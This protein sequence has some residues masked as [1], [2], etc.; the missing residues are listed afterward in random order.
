MLALLHRQRLELRGRLAERDG[1][2]AGAVSKSTPAAWRSPILTRPTTKTTRADRVVAASSSVP[3]AHALSAAAAEAPAPPRA[4]TRNAAAAPRTPPPLLS[5]KQLTRRITGAA[6]WR[7]AA[8]AYDDAASETTNAIHLAAAV[9][10]AGR[11]AG[12]GRDKASAAATWVVRTL[13]R[14][15]PRLLPECQP[16]QLATLLWSLSAALGVTHDG[17]EGMAQALAAAL[18]SSSSSSSSAGRDVVSSAWALASL[19]ARRPG[20]PASASAAALLLPAAWAA[21]PPERLAP[22]PQQLGTLLRAAA[23]LSL[24]SPPGAASSALLLPPPSWLE[25][26]W[27]MSSAPGWWLR[28]RA[29][30]EAA[31]TPGDAAAALWGGAR[32]GLAAGAAPPAAWVAAALQALGGAGGDAAAS[33]AEAASALGALRMLLGRS[34]LLC[35]TAGPAAQAWL[36]ALSQEGG[37]SLSAAGPDGLVTLARELAAL[38]PL[39]VPAPE[40]AARL[41]RRC[42]RDCPD[43]ASAVLVAVHRLL[44][45]SLQQQLGEEEAS[46]LSAVAAAAL[47]AVAAAPSSPLAPSAA[48]CVHAAAALGCPPSSDSDAD[49]A[50]DA[51]LRQQGAA[52]EERA[53]D[54][55]LALRAAATWA[56]TAEAA[57]A[58]A[59]SSAWWARARS[60]V[61]SPL[62]RQVQQQSGRPAAAQAAVRLLAALAPP[63]AAPPPLQQQQQPELLELRR[64]LWRCSLLHRHEAT[65]VEAAEL[66]LLAGRA[67]GGRLRPPSQRWLQAALRGVVGAADSASP[68]PER[69]LQLLRVLARW[70]ALSSAERD[71]L[72][73]A[74]AAA[75]VPAQQ[76]PSASAERAVRALRAASRLPEPFPALDPGWVDA[77]VDAVVELDAGQGA[78]ATVADSSSRSLGR[79]QRRPAPPAAVAAL[80]L[81]RLLNPSSAGAPPAAILAPDRAR[82][83]LLAVAHALPCIERPALAVAVLHA[84]AAVAARAGAERAAAP[85]ADAWLE[86][87][88]SRGPAAFGAAMGGVP[89]FT[90]A[91]WALAKSGAVVMDGEMLREVMDAACWPPA[92]DET[93][94]AGAAGRGAEGPESAAPIPSPAS[95]WTPQR[96]ANTLCAFTRLGFNPG[97]ERLARLGAELRDAGAL[98]GRGGAAGSGVGGGGAM[99]A[100]DQEVIVAAWADLNGSAYRAS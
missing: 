6:D 73:A 77:V 30:D 84:S 97:A 16:R 72:V 65:P 55:G 98:G 88:S 44:G 5:P 33:A 96:L 31:C 32:L 59:P 45:G 48:A 50:L 47:A 18:S 92:D 67:A 43:A 53:R 9:W 13:R 24:S 80:A 19:E 12:G 51:A 82:R 11:A 66:L 23:T 57:A 62:L 89:G 79:R 90:K 56:A 60:D 40:L 2:I 28:P 7:D 10:R 94:E 78:A 39:Q 38:Q 75:L 54:A 81:G 71:A 91:T 25:R 42:R 26:A 64:D 83:L 14:D 93:E 8:R 86:L 63:A 29:R 85:V 95:S 36:Q 35:P 4:S 87:V 20:H 21:H 70:R 41:L 99:A 100:L 52:A 27:A 61:V 46:D 15:L 68:P 37:L 34:A 69:W 3:V 1:A 76:Q 58:G 22:S 17:D 74:A 49:A